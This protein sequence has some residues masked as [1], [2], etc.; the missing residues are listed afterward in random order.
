MEI[1]IFKVDKWQL[2]GFSKKKPTVLI[3]EDSTDDVA[4]I[5]RAAVA[6]GISV[7]TERTAEGALGVLHKNGKDYIAVFVDVGLPYKDGWTLALEINQHWPALTV[8]VMSGAAERLGPPTRG[9]MYDVLWKDSNFYEVF[10]QLKR[11][12]NL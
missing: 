5:S 8:C 4:I 7:V 6:E 3:V 10:R 12:K 2:P 11:W 9:R 1:N